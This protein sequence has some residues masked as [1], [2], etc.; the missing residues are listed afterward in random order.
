VWPL[1]AAV[2]LIE[3]AARIGDP[4]QAAGALER[5]SN[6]TSA[7]GTEWA[8]GIEAF[9]RALQSDGKTAEHLYSEALDRLSRT[10]IRWALGRTHLVYG[11]WL[12]RE[13]R[14]TDARE[15]LRIAHQ[16][17]VTMGADGFA[18][19]A[20]HELGATGERVR[21]RT[22]GASFQ[23]TARETQIAR[24]AD[25][26]LSNP[27]IAAQLFMSRRTV[28]YHL[29]K[30]FTKLAISSRN[31]LHGVLANGGTVELGRTP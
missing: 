10:R 24:L 11:E 8:L 6:S 27:E 7:S 13:N 16:M 15:Q 28:E 19:R 20:A 17:F 30:I 9:A 14:R 3:A 18:E 1:L 5:L 29:H 31:Q 26:G 22:T 23:L 21:K 25:D 4:E 12:R 2:E